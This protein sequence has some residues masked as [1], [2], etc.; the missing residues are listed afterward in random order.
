MSAASAQMV[1][2]SAASN[3][4][5]YRS[6]ELGG[7]S[8]TRDEYFVRVGWTAKGQ[9][10]THTISADAF[11]RAMM[12]DVAWGFFYGWVNFDAVIGTR[13]RYGKV[14]FYAG[15]Y[16]SAYHDKGLDLTQTFETPQILATF[17]AILE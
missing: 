15:R 12:R 9:A 16:Y 6:F 5:G 10:M 13:N 2:A 17:K 4:T 8:F 11:L 1:K 7:F 14:E 3:R